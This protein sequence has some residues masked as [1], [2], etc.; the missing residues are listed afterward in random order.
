MGSRVSK[1]GA[2]EVAVELASVCLAAMLLGGS[3]V[4][5]QA[6][7]VGAAT[8][9]IVD[10]SFEMIGWTADKPDEKFRDLCSATAGVVACHM[11]TQIPYGM[12][13]TS[14]KGTLHGNQI[15]SQAL[16]QVSQ[17]VPECTY[18]SETALTG[19]INLSP[20]G[21]F[22]N[23]WTN[24]PTS[25]TSV[26]GPCAATLPR[27]TPPGPP[28]DWIGTWRQLTVGTDDV[29]TMAERCS[30]PRSS[31][32]LA[33][34]A[35]LNTE[36][37]LD[38]LRRQ[39]AIKSDVERICFNAAIVRYADAVESLA[40]AYYDALEAR[41]TYNAAIQARKLWFAKQTDIEESNSRSAEY[42]NQVMQTL[43][44]AIV[45]TAIAPAALVATALSAYRIAL[46]NL[47]D[48]VV[49]P[50]FHEGLYQSYR[51]LRAQH[52][53]VEA[54]DIAS[55]AGG[56]AY[57]LLVQQMVPLVGAQKLSGEERSRVLAQFWRTR[58][59]ARYAV[60][61]VIAKG[62]PTAQINAALAP[63]RRCIG[64]FRQEVAKCV[65]EA[66]SK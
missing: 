25:Y 61:Q 52:D 34:V 3:P 8:P 41:A 12:L 33:K 23:R 42:D 7:A 64:G 50:P 5:A 14:I 59:E 9:L 6:Q 55:S 13:K 45:G 36:W 37:T 29:G 66:T 26:T 30:P 46:A 32:A 15:V 51:T 65:Q 21:T 56:S 60:D 49:L 57:H 19:T 44:T 35:A 16:L 38:F 31:E 48:L 22:T 2:R 4:V 20:D 10:G 40:P 58:F 27:T 24:G 62:P 63:A 1:N 28:S 17:S 18:S 11:Q 54:F 47:R 39:L 53:S 43:G